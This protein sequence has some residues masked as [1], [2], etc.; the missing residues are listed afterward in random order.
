MDNVGATPTRPLR[1]VSHVT[2]NLG[3][4]CGQ[5]IDTVAVANREVI[6]QAA[7][8]CLDRAWR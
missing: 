3:P 2:C 8:V 4:F 5:R 7:R 6:G 1:E